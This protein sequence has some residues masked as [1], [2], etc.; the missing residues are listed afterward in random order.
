[1]ARYPGAGRA[2]VDLVGQNKDVALGVAGVVLGSD[3]GKVGGSIGFKV[4]DDHARP[5]VRCS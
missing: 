3:L 5:L 1:M 4:E 2:G